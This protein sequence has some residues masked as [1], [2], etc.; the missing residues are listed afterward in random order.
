MLYADSKIYNL[1][2]T[3]EYVELY[4]REGGIINPVLNIFLKTS[5]GDSQLPFILKN[6]CLGACVN[7]GNRIIF[8]LLLPITIQH[9]PGRNIMLNWNLTV[10]SI[11]HS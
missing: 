6:K 9:L 8:P 3:L 7:A 11:P 10:I 4:T 2:T 5:F 1:I